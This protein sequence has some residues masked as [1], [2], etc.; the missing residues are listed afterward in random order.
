[1]S[2]RDVLGWFKIQSYLSLAKAV[3]N[4][5]KTAKEISKI[6]G[7]QDTAVGEMLAN[8][9]KSEAVEYTG[10]GWKITALGQ[11]VLKKYFG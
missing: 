11:T 10:S 5:P 4:A 9:E 2:E 8:L 1:M 3:E 7:Y 6:I